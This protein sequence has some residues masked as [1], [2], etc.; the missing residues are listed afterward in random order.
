MKKRSMALLVVISITATLICGCGSNQEQTVDSAA[1]TDEV[2][3]VNTE[4]VIQ[5]D[6]EMSTEAETEAESEAATIDEAVSNYNEAT[7][8]KI[9]DSL[10]YRGVVADVIP[11]D[12]GNYEI[13]WETLTEMERLYIDE[14]EVEKFEI[15]TLYTFRDDME[16]HL[17]EIDEYGNYYFVSIYDESIKTAKLDGYAFKVSPNGTVWFC[18]YAASDSFGD[19]YTYTDYTN[20]ATEIA[21]DAEIYYRNSESYQ[22]ETE[23]FRDFYEQEHV[24]GN[25]G[26]NSSNCWRG[27]YMLKFSYI[28]NGIIWKVW[29]EELMG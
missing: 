11:L 7:G 12:S 16:C 21:G 20:V 8:F 28:E 4:V 22:Y 19:E 26:H 29:E 25:A 3:A 1:P 2:S 15:G 10:E 6:T 18:L 9:D 5:T 14:A 23:I 13:I 27:I 17:V 24:S